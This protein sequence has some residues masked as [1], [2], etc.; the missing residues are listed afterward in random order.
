MKTL[1]DKLHL[2]NLY[3]T[4]DRLN[5]LLDERDKKLEYMEE[6][7]KHADALIVRLAHVIKTSK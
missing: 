3:E 4:V 7:L 2:D 5:Y 1:V 6:T